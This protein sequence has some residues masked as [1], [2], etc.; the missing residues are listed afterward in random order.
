M[1]TFLAFFTARFSFKVLPRFFVL[2][3]WMVL[4]AM[5]TFLLLRNDS[6]IPLRW[7]LVPPGAV[8]GPGGIACGAKTPAVGLPD[9][10]GPLSVS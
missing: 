2:A 10:F 4:L 6:D 3:F 7:R 9:M 5:M 8:P 1:A